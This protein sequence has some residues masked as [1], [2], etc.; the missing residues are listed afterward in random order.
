MEVKQ[1]H[2]NI[3]NTAV[4]VCYLFGKPETHLQRAMKYE[5]LFQPSMN[6]F[7]LISDLNIQGEN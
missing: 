7:E 6:N 4:N 2:K 5:V 3:A 1:R